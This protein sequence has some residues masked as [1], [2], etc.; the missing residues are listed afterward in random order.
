MTTPPGSPKPVVATATAMAP[1]SAVPGASP[2][3]P[4]SVAPSGPSPHGLPSL[5]PTDSPL[6][7]AANTAPMATRFHDI[8]P[9]PSSRWHGPLRLLN[10]L[11]IG[12]IFLLSGRASEETAPID[13][14]L[15]NVVP[16]DPSLDGLL[17][18]DRSQ[19]R[20]SV[21]Q[22]LQTVLDDPFRSAASVR[23]AVTALFTAVEAPHTA[24]VLATILYNRARAAEWDA[25]D[26][27]TF[28]EIVQAGVDSVFARFNHHLA[29]SA[30]SE[31][32]FRTLEE[33]TTLAAGISTPTGRALAESKT[34]PA[35]TVLWRKTGWT[36][37]AD[38]QSCDFLEREVPEFKAMIEA[39]YAER[40]TVAALFETYLAWLQTQHVDDAALARVRGEYITLLKDFFPAEQADVM[41]RMREKPYG[42]ALEARVRRLSTDFT[43]QQRDWWN[44]LLDL[45]QFWH[46]SEVGHVIVLMFLQEGLIGIGNITRQSRRIARLLPFRQRIESAQA[47][48]AALEQRSEQQ[49]RRINQLLTTLVGESNPDGGE[50]DQRSQAEI[51]QELSTRQREQTHTLDALAAQREQLD[52]AYRAISALGVPGRWWQHLPRRAGR[53]IGDF[54]R[55]QL[56]WSIGLATASA[57]ILSTIQFQHDSD[58]LPLL[59]PEAA[60]QL[61]VRAPSDRL[62]ELEEA[63]ALIRK[64]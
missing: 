23:T 63:N 17:W 25:H 38:G 26:V 11:V 16:G 2:A 31:E 3:H 15:G 53:A 60:L 39:I 59:D 8:A 28:A 52:E 36:C 32:A 35:G 43:T 49:A 12:V 41:H 14:R 6:I 10:P 48:I 29:A 64:D 46:F 57:M 56:T 24:M 42:D 45:L 19:V 21:V 7:A 18:I 1:G 40:E 5:P 44:R 4:S 20:A 62:T 50:Q 30:A 13:A 61:R 54:A 34:V 22:Q 27:E 9:T 58:P 55:Y 51:M 47:Q 33:E 37:H